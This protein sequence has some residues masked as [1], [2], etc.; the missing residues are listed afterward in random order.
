MKDNL[1]N[2]AACFSSRVIFSFKFKCFLPKV[3]EPEDTTKSFCFA[4][5][6]LKD[7]SNL[8]PVVYFTLFLINQD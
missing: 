7:P 2:C 1:T 8:K 4:A 3:I 5:I 6:I